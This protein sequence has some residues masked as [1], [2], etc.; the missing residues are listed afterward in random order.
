MRG[1]RALDDRRFFL[2][3]LFAGDGARMNKVK[4]KDARMWQWRGR[5]PVCPAVGSKAK[6]AC[7]YLGEA[8]LGVVS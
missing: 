6:A 1:G 5:G 4:E 8:Q 3:G 2:A 7:S